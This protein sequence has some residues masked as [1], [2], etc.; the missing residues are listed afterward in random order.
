MIKGGQAAQVD[1]AVGLIVRDG[2]VLIAW[3]DAGRHQGGRYE[4]S[5]GKVD[6]GERIEIALVRE[7]QEELGIVVTAQRFLQ[8]LTYS[9]PEKTVCLHVYRV[10]AF[11]GEPSGVEGQPVRWVRPE[12]LWDYQFPAANVP[13]IR[14]AQ[15]PAVYVISHPLA[16]FESIEAWLHFHVQAV[17]ASAWLY[18]R[19][20]DGTLAQQ[21]IL[22]QALQQQRSDLR[23]VVA[24]ALFEQVQDV[25]GYHLRHA[26][27]AMCAALP[28][29]NEQQL[30]FASV[31]DALSIQAAD[32]VG[33]DAMLLG[34]VLSTASHPEQAGIGWTVFMQLAGLSQCPVYALGGQSSA[35]LATA[36]AHGAYG[37]A[38]IR[39]MLGQ[40]DISAG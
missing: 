27:L 25:A 28:R 7:L 22:I 8:R 17:A 2:Q 5:G 31:H 23:L 33:V 30:W 11:E 36:Q 35:T 19:V 6:A 18:V 1:V 24:S 16:A 14:A 9:Y 37:V 20:P 15:L 39:G 3:R 40:R 21:C 12:Q 32:T 10:D 34:A 26:D 13:I 4:F 29:H 38:G